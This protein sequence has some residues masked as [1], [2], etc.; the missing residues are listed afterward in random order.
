MQKR[1][2][3]LTLFSLL[4][5]GNAAGFE[6]DTSQIAAPPKAELPAE[7]M[8]LRSFEYGP[9]LRAL[10]IPK[11]EKSERIGTRVIGMANEWRVESDPMQGMLLLANTKEVLLG[12]SRSEEA[13][14]RKS[15]L[16]LLNKLGVPDA[17]IGR[18][19]T[20]NLMIR[21][22]EDTGPAQ[23]MLYKTFVARQI[24][25]VPVEGHRAVIAHEGNGILHRANL[26]W[27]ALAAAGHRLKTRVS[28]KEIIKRTEVVLRQAGEKQGRV[29]LRWKYLPVQRPSGEVVLQLVVGAR[30]HAVSGM[31]PREFS[32]P[33]DAY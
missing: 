26:F 9:A 16:E 14:V 2:V 19:Q 25:G 8:T 24:N 1:T 30:L 18:V 4:A 29:F 6:F 27:P 23:L 3:L 5:A 21:D 12:E 32:V 11:T 20:R 7:R 10:G 33:V 17:E 13:Q 31:E 22:E 15:S 28:V